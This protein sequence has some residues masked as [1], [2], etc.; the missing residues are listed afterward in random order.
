MDEMNKIID[1]VAE[2]AQ[3]AGLKTTIMEPIQEAKKGVNKVVVGVSS[4][5]AGTALGYG[6]A[7]GVD[8]IREKKSENELEA[9]IKQRDEL[10]K[11]IEARQKPAIEQQ[12]VEAEFVEVED[13]AE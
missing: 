5:I 2:R 3:N 12:F 4:A 7:R 13:P 6:L 9:M 10:N 1:D 8:A 11:K